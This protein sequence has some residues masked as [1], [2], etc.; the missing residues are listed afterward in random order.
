MAGMQQINSIITHNKFEI[1]FDS[2]G[3]YLPQNFR[4]KFMRVFEVYNRLCNLTPESH[5]N[6]VLSF[7]VVK[8]KKGAAL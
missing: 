6:N 5:P 1:F 2:H 3:T 4:A 8:K 7:E